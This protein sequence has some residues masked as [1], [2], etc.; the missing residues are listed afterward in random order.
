VRSQLSQAIL[1][2]LAVAW[3]R[4]DRARPRQRS[5]VPG[6]LFA[7]DEWLRWAVRVDAEL[8]GALGGAYAQRRAE[9]G[10]G[11]PLPG[12][13]HV[14]DLTERLGHPIDALVTVSAG[15]PA[16]FFDVRWRPYEDMPQVGDGDGGEHA[17]R[18]H[19]AS[20]PARATASDVT[21]FLL[22]AAVE[23]A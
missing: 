10:G 3:S 16:V 9:P 17:Y 11:R 6:L 19:L 5:E 7:L 14:Y 4:L 1:D 20:L 23:D 8:A 22:S 13:R 12:L 18:M 21:T 2:N 15:S